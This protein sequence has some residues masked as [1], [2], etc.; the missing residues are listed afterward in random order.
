MEENGG[1]WV[2]E[3]ETWTMQL[4]QK[5]F[6]T[7]KILKKKLFSKLG[8]FYNESFTGG[9]SFYFCSYLNKKNRNFWKRQE[10]TDRGDII[11]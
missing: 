9:K 7:I 6:K 11:L 1:K 4:I 3:E 8:F 2:R 10:K 5:K